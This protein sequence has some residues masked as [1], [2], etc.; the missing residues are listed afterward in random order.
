MCGGRFQNWT[1]TLAADAGYTKGTLSGT[2]G[3]VT[4]NTTVSATAATA[5]TPK[6][7]ITKA[8]EAYGFTV[9]YTNASGTVT[10][11]SNRPSSVTIKY[12]TTI[13]FNANTGSYHHDLLIKQGSTYK[14]TIDYNNTWTSGALTANTTF[15]VTG[16]D[17]TPE[18]SGGEGS[19]GEGGA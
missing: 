2:K 17:N 18:G 8:G 15:T 13:R 9:R 3:T 5:I 10:T 4:A 19:G 16:I 11:S 1:A 14:T 7:T 6:I 12:N